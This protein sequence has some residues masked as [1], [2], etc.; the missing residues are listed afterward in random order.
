MQTQTL[1][2]LIE[3]NAFGSVRPVEMVADAPIALLV[4]ALVQELHLPQ[5]DIFGNPLTYALRDAVEGTILPERATLRTVG[6]QPGARLALSSYSSYSNDNLAAPPTDTFAAT[7]AEPPAPATYFP[8]AEPGSTFHASETM[9]NNY[10]IPAMPP[11]NTT[12]HRMPA[13]QQ[14]Q[15]RTPRY[16]RRALLVSAVIVG[17]GG[18]G[19]AMVKRGFLNPQQHQAAQQP[20]PKPIAS[21][22]A[23]SGLPTKATQVFSFTGHQG[24]VRVVSWSPQSTTVASG[25]DDRHLMT[26]TTNGN[27]MLSIG[28]DTGLHALAW[29][30]DGQRIVTGAGSH[31]T[32]YDVPT[33]KRVGHFI[34]S[35]TATVTSL[36]WT[37]H[38][39]MQVLSGSLDTRV[40]VWNTPPDH[41][42]VAE[43]FR[44]HTS[45]VEAVTWASDGQTVAS[46]SQGGVVRVWNAENGQELH[47]FYLDAQLPMNAAAFAPSTSQLAIGGNDGIIRLWNG[48]TCQKQQASQFGNQCVDMPQRLQAS[49]AP[50]R[51][52]AWSADGRFLL[53]GSDDMFTLWYPQQS[54][55]PLLM[56]PQQAPVFSVSWSPTDAMLI[57]ASSGHIVNIW[58]LA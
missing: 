24:T 15:A 44:L 18:I 21:V 11:R 50:I 10:Q 28:H 4:P 32:F 27:V 20:P 1:E 39:Q 40:L 6:V 38:N 17:I 57:A 45:A 35:H 9:A 51:S 53:A 33:G 29:S 37:P 2:V 52:L 5:T 12:P 36:A 7:V 3:E 19:Y 14:K 54:Q 43:T 34:H 42:Q 55:K 23:Q 22:P 31:I 56:M 48:M 58:K 13:V 16:T 47:G 26:W 49:K 25:A 8:P 30:P 41:Y 46:A